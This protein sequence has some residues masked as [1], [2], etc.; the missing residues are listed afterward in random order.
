MIV[1]SRII[2]GV[3]IAA[4]LAMS[5]S[6]TFAAD[7]SKDQEQANLKSVLAFY[8]KGLNQKDAEGAIALG[9]A[10]VS[11]LAKFGV[12][13]GTDA[14]S[15]AEGAI[16]IGHAAEARSLNSVAIGNGAIAEGSTAVGAGAL[17]SGVDTAAFG[18]G[19]EATGVRATSRTSRRMAP[20]P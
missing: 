15:S 14:L 10:D 18:E 19:A 7:V 1:L 20:R 3:V 16:A 12:A 8:E 4:A 13:V 11:S 9:L 5:A 17:A 6:A 2:G